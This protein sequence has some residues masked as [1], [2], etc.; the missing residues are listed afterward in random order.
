MIGYNSCSND[1]VLL[2]DT[3]EFLTIDIHKL[4]LFLKSDK[5][6]GCSA[7]YNMCDYNVHFNELVKKYILF[8]KNKISALEHLNYLWLCGCK[9]T[10]KNIDYMSN[11][12]IGLMY[13]F[14]LNR[15]KKNNLIKFI[16][17]VLL[18]KK[19]RDLPLKLLD[20]DEF[21]LT[22][23]EILTIFRHSTRDKVNIPNGVLQLINN[24]E[25]IKLKNYS[26]VLDFEPVEMKGMV[27]TPVFLE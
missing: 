15:N 27:N 1:I 24:D 19:N 8:K 5:S 4:N 16:F 22:T 9:Q 18:Y 23:N 2:V 7:I 20:N 13:H 11:D 17:Y 10:E 14:T 6:V 26:N 25:T 12:E 3:D 21:D